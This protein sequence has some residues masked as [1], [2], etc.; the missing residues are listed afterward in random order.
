MPNV[1]DITVVGNLA[2]D[3][4]YFQ[5]QKTGKIVCKMTVMTNFGRDDKKQTI[6]FGII[7]RM[8]QETYNKNYYKYEGSKGKSV[9]VQGALRPKRG[10]DGRS[11][12]YLDIDFAR[13][14]P[15]WS[16]KAAQTWGGKAEQSTQAPAQIHPD[17]WNKQGP[18]AYVPQA[19]QMQP[20][21]QMPPQA[22]VQAPPRPPTQQQGFQ[23][24]PPAW[25]QGPQ[26]RPQQV[27]PVA[28]PNN[29][30]WIPNPPPTA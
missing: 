30:N 13:V 20:Q 14:I 25:P 21:M 23:S 2:S 8:D 6:A 9:F 7:T 22:A 19:P 24:S 3:P 29:G 4:Q 18:P 17:G 5:D 26:Q 11:Y 27:T 12:S 28:E 10:P 1:A 15:L 16:D